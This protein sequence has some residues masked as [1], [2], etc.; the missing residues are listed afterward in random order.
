M[1]SDKNKKRKSTPPTKELKQKQPRSS[2][3]TA[4]NNSTAE[5]KDEA[6]ECLASS[7]STSHDHEQGMVWSSP[8]SNL[9]Y[10]KAE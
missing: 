8:S 5:Q 10:C 9:M 4:S 6:S 2:K 1:N 7:A 3:L